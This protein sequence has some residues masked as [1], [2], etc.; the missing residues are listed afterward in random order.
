VAL[1]R[2]LTGSR[3]IVLA[4]ARTHG[5]YLFRGATCVDAAVDGYL[6]SGRLPAADL[7]CAE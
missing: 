5:V 2:A 1:H 3:M 4:G 6:R 7:T